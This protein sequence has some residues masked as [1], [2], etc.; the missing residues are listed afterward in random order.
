[1]AG[2]AGHGWGHS[3]VGLN[4]VLTVKLID[5]MGIPRLT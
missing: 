3:E 2:E 5:G 4:R 1:M